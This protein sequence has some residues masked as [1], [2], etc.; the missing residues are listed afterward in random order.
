MLS[1]YKSK[2]NDQ[3]NKKSDSKELSYLFDEYICNNKD[4]NRKV[5]FTF[6]DRK[7]LIISYNAG[8]I[9][10]DDVDTKIV[11]IIYGYCKELKNMNCDTGIYKVIL[12]YYTNYSYQYFCGISNDKKYYNNPAYCHV[13]KFHGKYIIGQSMYNDLFKLEKILTKYY[14]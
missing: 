5:A 14:H 12:G 2:N 1:Y 11:K 4:G 9:S 13:F 8:N 7:F 3:Y 6:F 10:T